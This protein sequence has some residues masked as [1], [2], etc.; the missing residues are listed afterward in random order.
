MNHKNSSSSSSILLNIL[1]KANE[2]GFE[3]DSEPDDDGT[4][5]DETPMNIRQ[6]IQN[7]NLNPETKKGK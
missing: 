3:E 4:R 6:G 7:N 1:D 2:S 5:Q